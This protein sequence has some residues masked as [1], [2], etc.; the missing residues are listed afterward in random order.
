MSACKLQLIDK[1]IELL[2]ISLISCIV[3]ILKEMPLLH[4]NKPLLFSN[5]EYQNRLDITVINWIELG[6]TLGNTWSNCTYECCVELN[7]HDSYLEC[8]L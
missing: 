5:W 3:G 4:W 8:N 1:P 7:E 6:P 2:R